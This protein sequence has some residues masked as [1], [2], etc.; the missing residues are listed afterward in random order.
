MRI[1]VIIVIA[2]AAITLAVFW[3]VIHFD[4]VNFDDAEYVFENP[5]VI[6]GFTSDGIVWAFTKCYFANWH[7]ITWLVHMAN[8]EMFGLKPGGHHLINLLLHIVYCTPLFI[9]DTHD[10]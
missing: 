5:H 4:F 3:Q 10:R 8:C 7:P 2:L 6:S 1:K 9:V